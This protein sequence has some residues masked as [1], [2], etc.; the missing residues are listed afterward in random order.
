M[1]TY[2]STGAPY[3]PDHRSH[4]LLYAALHVGWGLAYTGAGHSFH[5]VKT[6]Q[7]SVRSLSS[8]NGTCTYPTAGTA[9]LPS[10]IES[11]TG[12]VAEVHARTAVAAVCVS[13]TKPKGKG[14]LEATENYAGGACSGRSIVCKDV[15]VVQMN[16]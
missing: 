13:P 9:L 2:P 4:I 7:K 16:E 1:F 6:T 8:I 11:V 3:A 10:I 14:R 15:H 5:S 12:T